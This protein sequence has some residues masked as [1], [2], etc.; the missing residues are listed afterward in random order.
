[1]TKFNG[2]QKDI[3][4]SYENFEYILHSVIIAIA[5]SDHLLWSLEKIAK[6]TKKKNKF[7]NMS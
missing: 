1:M 2:G 4:I 5:I 3:Y 7:E 6:Y